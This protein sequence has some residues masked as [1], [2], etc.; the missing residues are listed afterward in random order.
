M[1]ATLLGIAFL[2]LLLQFLG[3]VE[4]LLTTDPIVAADMRTANLLATLRTPA[5]NRVFLFVTLLGKWPVVLAYG[6]TASGILVLWRKWAFIPGLWVCMTGASVSTWLGKMVFHRQRPAVAEYVE[7]SYS[8]PSGH[9]VISVALYGFLVYLAWRFSQKW[10]LKLTVLLAGSAV[11]LVI[12]TSRLYLGVHYLSDVWG[13]YL[14]GFMWLIAGISLSEAAAFRWQSITPVRE[15]PFNRVASWTLAAAAIGTY[16]ILGSVYNPP[17]KTFSEEPLKVAEQTV[18]SIFIDHKLPRYTETLTGKDQE[19]LSFV[20]A[21]ASEQDLVEVFR[22]AG[23]TLASRGNLD[24]LVRAG[25]AAL[26]DKP[27]PEAPMTPSFWHGAPH[28]LGFEKPLKHATVRERHHVRFWKTGLKTPDDLHIYVGTASLDIGLKW[29]IAHKIQANI[30][31]E[32]EFLF[33]DLIG[34]GLVKSHMKADFVEPL[35]GHNFIGDPFFTDGKVYLV[36]FVKKS[37]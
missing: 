37:Q 26:T 8:F 36:T 19:P 12:G 17:G 23:W 25:K 29:G 10:R 14:L 5:L 32:R 18:A 27:D 33:T 28:D 21:A 6:F 31:A 34:T 24:D 3:I 13:G 20:I 2:F 11:I 30:D 1:P 7:W 15:G 35:F 22:R 4:S 9:A 16:L